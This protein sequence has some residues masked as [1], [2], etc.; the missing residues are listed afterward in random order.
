MKIVQQLRLLI[1]F[2]LGLTALVLVAIV[3]QV[4]TEQESNVRLEQILSLS[5]AIDTLAFDLWTLKNFSDN[6]LITANLL[7]I[8]H[9]EQALAKIPK[10]DLVIRN[11][12][13]ILERDITQVRKLLTLSQQNVSLGEQSQLIL[14][15]SLTIAIQ[16]LRESLYHYKLHVINQ[17]KHLQLQLMYLNGGVLLAF[18]LLIS[19]GAVLLLKRFEAGIQ[20]LT[21]GVQQVACGEL[22]TPVTS[23]Y[24]DE[25]GFLTN[26]FN[27]MRK[28][29]QQ[30]TMLKAELEIEVS[31]Q[32]HAL[33]QQA[34]QLQYVAEHDDLCGLLSKNTFERL[35]TIALE[36]CQRDGKKG[37]LIFID[38]NG[39]KGINDTYGHQCGDMALQQLSS[40]LQIKLRKSDLIGRF[41]GD[42][43]VLWL[44]NQAKVE[45]LPAQ[46]NKLVTLI[47]E[48][49]ELNGIK[50]TL[51]A[52]LGVS[53]YP[54]DG[55]HN[56]E[57]LRKA[58]SAM[59][60]AKNNIE[61]GQL[62]AIVFAS[63]TLNDNVTNN[64]FPYPVV[65]RQT[66]RQN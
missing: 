44:D 24:Q 14:L 19:I 35:F 58:D 43:F 42:E 63:H 41:G 39:F 62:S 61:A 38:L 46:L 20:A 17:H 8:N 29:L 45:A 60:H 30:T 7:E 56:T 52:S 22:T 57:L 50:L 65:K 53:R 13:T 55:T 2:S 66:K 11:D 27:E 10:D 51:G 5:S 15:S 37:V 28:N 40:R 34:K 59:Y 25:L 64:V 18:A 31:R 12:I 36:R 33:Q 49:M 48:P 23:D 54:E 9:I 26:H 6:K 4:Q 47:E 21:T 16:S 1:I 32:T 3:K